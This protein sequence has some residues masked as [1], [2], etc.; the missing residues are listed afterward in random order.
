[1]K[2]VKLSSSCI[3]HITGYNSIMWLRKCPIKKYKIHRCLEKIKALSNSDVH[4]EVCRNFCISVQTVASLG[5][6]PPTFVLVRIL[7]I[8]IEYKILHYGRPFWSVSD[9]L[10]PA[11]RMLSLLCP[12]RGAVCWSERRL[13][14]CHVFTKEITLEKA[15]FEK[16]A[17]K[18]RKK[19]RGNERK[20]YGKSN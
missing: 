10:F 15:N 1:M 11:R 9:R 4:W 7:A 12:R 2:Q 17:T 5:G 8:A 3:G 20:A 16:G 14:T 18:G 6:L 19:K 13:A